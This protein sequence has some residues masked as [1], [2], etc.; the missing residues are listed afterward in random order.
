VLML[1][2]LSL[3]APRAQLELAEEGDA[4]RVDGFTGRLPTVRKLAV[5]DLVASIYGRATLAPDLRQLKAKRSKASKLTE[6]L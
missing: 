3:T 6:V 2:A 4:A 5:T 1:L